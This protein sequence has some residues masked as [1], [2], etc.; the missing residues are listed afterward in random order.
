MKHVPS[1]ILILAVL[2]LAACAREPFRVCFGPIS[3]GDCKNFRS[4][5]HFE[6]WEAA[7]RE[8]QKRAA[9]NF[10]DDFRDIVAV[11]LKASFKNNESEFKNTRNQYFVSVFGEDLDPTTQ[12]KLLA[13]G[14]VT[15]PASRYVR[16]QREPAFQ[17]ATG[18]Y[19]SN[20]EVYVSSIKRLRDG[21]YDVEFGYN[22]G[23][24]CAGHYIE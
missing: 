10:P 18:T 4:A 20:T 6:A 5:E 14:L 13:L 11:V 24:L 23:E 22:C 1:L 3:S 19:L 2:V 16:S 7:E 9:A 15:E 12:A 8:K 21:A 17:D